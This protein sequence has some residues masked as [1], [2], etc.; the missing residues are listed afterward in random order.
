MA[1]PIFWAGQTVAILSIA[2]I[3]G[4]AYTSEGVHA[5]DAH[6]RRRGFIVYGGQGVQGL[7]AAREVSFGLHVSRECRA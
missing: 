1:V 3:G 5:V 2:F 6:C 7:A 4:L